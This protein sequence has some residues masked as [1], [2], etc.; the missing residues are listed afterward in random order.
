MLAREE[1]MVTVQQRLV[2]GVGWRTGLVR[3]HTSVPQSHV[4]LER[5]LPTSMNVHT[6][7]AMSRCHLVWGRLH[8]AVCATPLQHAWRDVSV[9]GAAAQ[10][11]WRSMH[12]ACCE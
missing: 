1:W 4:R 7:H 8:S 12:A 2:L 6:V 11:A 5:Q 9:H 3:V 10:H